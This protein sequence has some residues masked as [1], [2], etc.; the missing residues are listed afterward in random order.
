MERRI[1]V[2]RELQELISHNRYKVDPSKKFISRCIDG[3]YENSS[4]LPA[5][6]IPGADAGE[7][8][9]IFATGN[10]Y[11]FEVDE[12][13]TFETLVKVVGGIENLRFH[14]DAHASKDSVLAGCGHMK[15][16]F[17]KIQ[18]YHIEEKETKFIQEK[19][20]EA[21]N[22]GAKEIVLQG[23]H[24]EGAV[25]F[26]SG[27]Y[28]FFPQDDLEAEEGRVHAQAFI[29][30]KSLVDERHKILCEKLIENKAVKLFDGLD[31]EYLYQVL[32]Q[33]T[34]DHLFEAAK[35]LASG[36]P[37]YEVAFDDDGDFEIEK[38]DTV[39]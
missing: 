6:A 18:I 19:A 29:F 25:V 24:K 23:E 37:I 21:K 14:T 8:A 26:V 3:R 10:I 17:S 32:S 5:L 7:L 2:S 38:I 13:K 39:Q 20:R 11:G 30:H 33:T 1:L 34:E 16:I 9:L 4:D 36:L 15:Q 35:Q 28:S 22:E 27:D 12:E 31:G